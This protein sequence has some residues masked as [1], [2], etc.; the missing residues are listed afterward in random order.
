MREGELPPELRVLPKEG[1]EAY[2][3]GKLAERRKLQEEISSLSAERE[4]WLQANQGERQSDSA[5]DT[6]I[7]VP[8]ESLAKDKGF[9]STR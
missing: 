6:A 8:L 3:A 1:R 4:A 2:V 9:V 7:L 5:L